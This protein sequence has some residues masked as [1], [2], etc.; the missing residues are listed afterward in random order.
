MPRFVDISIRVRT[1]VAFGLVLLV[2]VGLGTFALNQISVISEASSDLGGKSMPSL[3]QSGEM[4]RAVINFRREEANRLLSVS[5]DDGRY[6]EGLMDG[7]SEKAAH[8]RKLYQPT[9]SEE[10]NAIGQFDLIWPQFLKSTSAILEA[11]KLDDANKA[12]QQYVAENR[13]QFDALN[14]ILATVVELNEV[15][16]QRSYGKLNSAM[17]TARIGVVAALVVAAGIALAAGIFTVLTTEAPIRRLTGAMAELSG[18]ELQAEIPD[19]DRKD[20]IG[21]MAQA[22]QIF[23]VGLVEADRLTAMQVTEEAQKSRRVGVIDALVSDFGN[24]SAEM[25]ASFSVAATQLDSTANEMSALATESTR[26]T[27]AAAAAVAD[28]TANVQ[29]VEVA[30]DKLATS[31][32]EISDQVGRAKKIAVRASED[33]RSTNNTVVGLTRATQKIGEVVTLIQAIAAQTNLLALNATIEAAR[34]GE[35]GKGFAVVASEVKALANQTAKATDEI[36]T[37]IAAVQKVSGETSSSIQSIGQTVEELNNI[38]NLIA[39]TMEQQGASTYEIARNVKQATAGTRGMA[40]TMKKVIDA[41]VQSG[42]ASSQ[43]LEAASSLAV[44]SSSLQSQ[45]STFLKEIKAA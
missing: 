15:A 18:R 43:V 37:Q 36:A 40:E 6:R 3:F 5:K 2:T 21:A 35:V 45:V 39:V 31:I 28:T 1:F 14:K 44:R 23:K 4:L 20:E 17:Q 25:L 26:Q 30:A 12:H 13:N 8:F 19:A 11:L 34:A 32:A 27:R 24:Q 41:A 16:G 29:S 33:I 10:T 22:V 42:N 38:S 7:Y 9:T